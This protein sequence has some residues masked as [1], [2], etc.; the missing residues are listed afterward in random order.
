MTLYEEIIQCAKELTDDEK[1]EFVQIL[2]EQVIRSRREGEP[3][4][5]QV[6]RGTSET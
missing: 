2:L 3:L 4:P 5:A 6:A 1:H